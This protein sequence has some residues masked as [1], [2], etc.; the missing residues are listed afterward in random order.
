[1]SESIVFFV[2]KGT[3]GLLLL[4][5]V[6]TWAVVLLKA[7]QRWIARRLDRRFR[8][9]NGD[10]IRIGALRGI[11]GQHGPAWRVVRAGLG[12]LIDFKTPASRADVVAAR[13]AA[14]H[15]LKQQIHRER[16]TAEGGLAVLA[17]IGS[18]SKG[19]SGVSESNAHS[20]RTSVERCQNLFS[21]WVW[22]TTR[23]RCSPAGTVVFMKTEANM[24][25]TSS[26]SA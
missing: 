14:E 4:A 18:T 12:A 1:M 19:P 5:S 9:A 2:V 15:A 22:V 3:F 8:R 24:S 21:R 26:S 17:S 25:S 13:E 6:V 11:E 20:V 10:V 7:R 16:R 23:K